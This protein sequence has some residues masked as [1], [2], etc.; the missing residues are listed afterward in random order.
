MTVLLV[1]M[2]VCRIK[3]E[4]TEGVVLVHNPDDPAYLCVS[5]DRLVLKCN[6]YLFDLKDNQVLKIIEHG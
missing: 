1:R 2:L 4:V 5:D 6:I 3:E